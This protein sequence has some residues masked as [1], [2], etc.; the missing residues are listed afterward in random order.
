MLKPILA[1][2]LVYALAGEC[3]AQSLEGTWA[4]IDGPGAARL[5]PCPGQ[6]ETICG[7]ALARA[8]DGGISTKLG[9]RVLEAIAPAGSSRWKGRYVDDGRN[10]P[11][12]LTLK[13]ADR[14]DMKVCLAI[15]C[16]TAR[17]RRLTP[18]GS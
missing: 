2:A 11:A 3:R 18:P 9:G 6:P 16:Q 12:T 8:G 13:A 7:Y 5:M 10:L 14:V 4:E 17:Y 15:V 1:A